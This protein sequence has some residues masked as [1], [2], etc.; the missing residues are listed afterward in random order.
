L[1]CWPS[2]VVVIAGSLPLIVSPRQMMHAC[3]H[4]RLFACMRKCLCESAWPDG[5]QAKCRM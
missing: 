5:R 3:M 2:V 1:L 4:K